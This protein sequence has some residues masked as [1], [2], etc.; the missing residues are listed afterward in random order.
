MNIIYYHTLP[1]IADYFCPKTVESAVSLLTRYGKEAQILAGGTDLLVAMRS[2]KL[3]P[4][5]L[6]DITGI[7][8]LDYITAHREGGINIGALTTIRTIELSQVIKEKYLLLYEA[9]HC[10]GTIQVN[11]L[12]TVAGNICRASPS[13][14]MACPLYALGSSVKIEGPRQTRIVSLSEFS[15]GSEKTALKDNELVTEIQV[16]ELAPCSGTAFLRATRVAS[17]LSKTNVSTVVTLKDGVCTD[18]RIVLGSVAPTLMRAAEAEEIIRG[19][20]IGKTLIEKSAQAASDA[21]HPRSG[22]LRATPEYKKVLA[23][24]LTEQALTLAFKRANQAG[25][26]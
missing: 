4:S 26:K 6:I 9:A 5:Y 23:K 18:I 1:P 15:I 11:N 8:S 3:T 21:A 10:M 14:D 25:G 13:A 2:R 20:K 24:I 7:V 22:S 19:K 16:P 12:A 17:D